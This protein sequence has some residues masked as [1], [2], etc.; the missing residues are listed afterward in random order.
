[1]VLPFAVAVAEG[2]GKARAQP[3]VGFGDVEQIAFERIG[4]E[5]VTYVANIYKHHIAYPLVGDAGRP[6]RLG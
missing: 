5:T 2:T 4:R 3:E 6:P 1:M